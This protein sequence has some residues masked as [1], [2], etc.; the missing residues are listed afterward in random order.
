[1]N[2]LLL[3]TGVLLAGIVAAPA[4]AE[5]VETRG[6]IKVTSDD[7]RFSARLGGRIHLDSNVWIDD[8]EF[9]DLPTGVFFRRARL[10]LEGEA[11]GWTYKFENDFA[12]QNGDNGSGFREMWIGTELAG[13]KLRLGQAKP[14][15]GMEE[16]TSS[17]DLL[18][19][20]RPFASGSGIYRQY[21]TGVFADAAGTNYGWGVA[22]YN[23][24][25]GA[26]SDDDTDGMGVTARGY[27]LPVLGDEVLFHVGG[28]ASLDKPAN[29]KTVGASVRY[30][31]RRG[32]SQG[33]GSTTDEQQSL[34]LELA[35]RVGAL[36]LQS[37]YHFVTLAQ[38][39]GEDT[40]LSAA[41]VQLSWLLGGEV[42]PYDV[43]KGVFKSPKPAS[44]LGAWELKL[45]YDRIDRKGNDPDVDVGQLSAGANW[46]VNPNVRFM[47]EYIQGEVDSNVE[48]SLVA[49]RAQ[50]SF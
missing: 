32:P 47:F 31:G 21:Q 20:E 41:Y 49:A 18:F 19:M 30:A 29:G 43:K 12:G 42:K 13:V 11:Y 1:M 35:G 37:E 46:F 15:R 10:T 34:G 45:R 23:L 50:L 17:N 22:A 3:G 48:G 14:Y 6:G 8:D 5:T 36:A 4:W 16:L 2:K 27:V 9:G 33:L 38:P 40:E 44:A 28:I 7:G 26:D 39:A 24:R 25:N